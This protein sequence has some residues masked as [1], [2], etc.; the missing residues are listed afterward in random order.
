MIR[1]LL[2]SASG[3]RHLRWAREI[4]GGLRGLL[5]YEST[6]TPEQHNLVL[7]EGAELESLISKLSAAAKTYRDFLE[8]ERTRARGEVRAATW[9]ASGALGGSDVSRVALPQAQ[10][11]LDAIELNRETHARQVDAA[12]DALRDG[13]ERLDR[14]L[15]GAFPPTILEAVYPP[16]TSDWAHV[17][18][19]E[20]PNDDATRPL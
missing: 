20:D 1:G 15:L 6:L 5:A 17:K 7:R 4:F 8:R 9:I 2:R 11:K 18:D 10:A 13:L 3:L 12:I 19:N 14:A 16:L